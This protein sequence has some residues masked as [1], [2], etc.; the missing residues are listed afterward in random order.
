MQAKIID[1]S[2]DKRCDEFVAN[3]SQGTEFHLSKWARV[4]QKT[5]GL[6]S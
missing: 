3:Y 6:P 4:I 2:K 5:Y 1:P